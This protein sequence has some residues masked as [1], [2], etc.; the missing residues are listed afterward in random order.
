MEKRYRATYIHASLNLAHMCARVMM[1]YL[2]VIRLFF[3]DENS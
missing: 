1:L 3:R 2:S